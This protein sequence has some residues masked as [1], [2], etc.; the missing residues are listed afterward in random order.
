MNHQSSLH[1]SRRLFRPA[2]AALA[3]LFSATLS[4]KAASLG[5][6]QSHVTNSSPAGIEITDSLGNH[7]RF[8]AYGT[9]MIRVQA[10]TNATFSPDDRYLMIENHSMGGALSVIS[11]TASS[12]VIVNGSIRLTV[13]KNPLRL[14][15]ADAAGNPLVS[16]AGGID[17]NATT[18]TYN[19]T[20]DANE[21]FIG[22]GQKR[23]ALQD[24]FELAGRTERRNYGEE[25]F[26][27]RGAQGV[28]CVPFYISSKGYGFYA[29]TTFP[30]EGRFNN[31]GDYSFRIE[32][33]S[34]A[35][36][37]ADYF[38]IYGPQPAD[39]L[40]HYTELTGRPRMP[41]KAIFGLHLSDHDPLIG[42]PNQNGAWWQATVSN[43]F[44]AGFPLDHM[45]YDN[46]WRAASTNVGGT[47]GTWSGSQFAFD[48]TR[49]PD[50]AAFRQWYDS[51][52]LMLTLDLNLNTCNDSAG[53]LPAY[54][55]PPY[56][57]STP[58]NVSD[59][60]D[61][62]Y[63]NPAT[64]A[65][66]WQLFWDKALNPVLGYPGD[67]L[68]LDEP[69]AIG[70]SDGQLLANGRPWWEMKNYYFFLNAYAAVAEGWDNVDGGTTPGIGEAKRPWV[71]IRGGTP[72]MQRYASH[73]TGD[74][75]YST[76][77]W[78]GNI[79]GMQ[80]SGLAGFPYYNHDAGAFGSSATSPDPDPDAR[81]Q[82][83]NDNYYIQWS[84]GL[85]S[86]SP[87]WRPHGYGNP[88]WPY[89]RSAACQT[90][91]RRYATMRYE[92]MPYIYSIAHLAHDS[93]L[94]MVRPMSLV[95]PHVPEA[96]Q[97]EQEY[98]YLWGD[99]FL[100]VPNFLLNGA[101]ETR[102]A[103]LPPAAWYDFWT[104]TL[105]GNGTN[106]SFYTF[107]ARF[108]YLP[109]F[110]KAGAIIPRQNFAL[111][112]AFLSDTNLTLDV[113]QGD[114]GS[115]TMIEDD[116]VTE[117][118]RTRGEERVTQFTYTEPGGLP[119][120]NIGAAS[121]TYTNASANRSY[122]VRLHGLSASPWQVTVDGAPV[123]IQPAPL[124]GGGTNVA[125]WDSTNRLMLV[126]V[127]SRAVTATATVVITPANTP[128]APTAL[129]ATAVSSSQIN[130]T[131]TDNATNE[132]GFKIIRK[133]GA[134]GIYAQVA[135]VAAN[136]TSYNATGLADETQYFYRICATNG[137]GD[138]VFGIEATATTFP[139]P[140]LAP[141]GLATATMA[142]NQISLTWADNSD[143]ETGFQIERSLTSDGGFAII[144]TVGA[145]ITDFNDT[146]LPAS[147]VFY[148]R[149]AA[150]N[151]V[152]S[153]PYSSVVAGTTVPP[154]PPSAPTGLTAAVGIGAQIN[155]TWTDTATN[156]TGFKLQRKTG[157]G[158]TYSQ[159]AAF[160]A[161][162]TS[163]A[164][165]G[166]AGN[167]TYYYRLSATNF[168]GDS[169]LSNETNATTPV[170]G[171]VTLTGSDALGSSSFDTAGKWNNAQ[172]PSATNDYFTAG[173]MLRTPNNASGNVTFAGNSLSLDANGS[174]LQKGVNQSF[175]TIAVLKLNGGTLRNGWGDTTQTI[176]GTIRVTASSILDPD[177]S[178]RYTVLAAPI[179][180][181]GNLRLISSE[182]PGGVVQ[183]T[184]T[185]DAFTGNWTVSST[186]TLQV[187]LGGNSGSLGSGNVTNSGQLI[188]DRSDVFTVGNRIS[189]T[190]TLVMNGS[191][192]L[193]L[194]GTNTYN[195]A[196]AIN[197]GT[198][199]VNGVLGN[200]A[201]TVG[202]GALLGGTGVIS[203]AVS[204]PGGFAPG[205]NGIGKLTISDSLTLSGGATFEINKSLS[206]SNDLVVVTGA[207]NPGGVLAVN[208]LGDALTNGDTFALF[209]KAVSG[210]F[211]SVTLPALPA[212]LAWQD[213]LAVN[214][215]ISVAAP[216]VGVASNPNPAN[217]ATDI[218][219]NPTL[220]WQAG[221]YAVSHRIY[222][223]AN[224]NAVAVA[225]TNSPEFKG[226]LEAGSYAPGTLASSGRFFWRVDAVGLATSAFGATWTFA[227]AVNPASKPVIGG[228]FNGGNFTV[229]F[230]SQAGQTYRVERS[231]SLNPA[232]WQTVS[233]NIPGTGFP[234]QIPDTGTGS[235]VQ[236]FYRTLVLLP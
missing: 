215:T 142:T 157:A 232:N 200:T 78:K 49:Y 100:V 160:A 181:S 101:D 205:A 140:P 11:E 139:V 229:S 40:D 128:P 33:K 162:T 28:L 17:L 204:V 120:F 214:G 65:W 102:T 233:N 8:R 208:N 159:I 108:G 95:Y 143:N 115:F 175:V 137:N 126:R 170:I 135:T 134:N 106:G 144:G 77:F 37:E 164:D 172:V 122:I 123:V 189:G 153:S 119:T 223:G 152:G 163:Y 193:T 188:F 231:D 178:T 169:A 150:T 52:G 148:Y 85:G 174:L 57:V 6:Y 125:A 7:L 70:R 43:H 226:T 71:W 87:I 64:R 66:L 41:R 29:N 44:N 183:L 117:R 86:F 156:E 39:I 220:T 24:T 97:H 50:P 118:F 16:D 216:P 133:V 89:N 190:G 127:S 206:P 230:A 98:Q 82:G 4:S 46:N 130:L 23:L 177:N 34:L 14:S 27:G 96:W 207:L 116:G 228:G 194:T 192:T 19:F 191:G 173:N 109:V 151:S 149:V 210:S 20:P 138:S 155:L 165:I 217:G 56:T 75:E 69:D 35:T 9:N 68:W 2:L 53:W 72:G 105:V 146:G 168:G 103:W 129:A 124:P 12:L 5:N 145:G 74:I 3:V 61:P 38:F 62:D 81:V 197:N 111:T 31:A 176:Y 99:A 18:L 184:G 67:A 219:T 227:T 211:S 42:F 73:W 182:G 91:F 25:G 21:K 47:V 198:V 199:L 36:P 154:P 222:F 141:S 13:S 51:K 147:S 179:T 167:T 84:C 235:S 94:P 185:S 88:R 59:T 90:A 48:P 131:W 80:A 113:Y 45:V 186:N 83:P 26:P 180:G 104:D 187:G 54:N 225:T 132:T 110:V 63:S 136:A 30:H 76:N 15:Y 107:N 212:G 202:F 224:S 196:T 234:I 79:I 161:N 218:A 213:N 158:G 58:P 32:I 121:G 209:N 112:T 171:N 92:M 22:Y 195:G 55:I 201:V 93:G 166:L 221:D 60:S 203:G 114:S 1:C 10:A 236:R